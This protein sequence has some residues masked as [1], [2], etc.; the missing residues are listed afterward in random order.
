MNALLYLGVPMMAKFSPELN[1]VRSDAYIQF[2]TPEQRHRG[3]D[4]AILSKRTEVYAAAKERHPE[5]WSKETRD[6]SPI[7]SV[8]LNPDAQTRK[9]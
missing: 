9:N 1:M 6:W 3:E 7:D 2:I 4:K 8:E 5:R